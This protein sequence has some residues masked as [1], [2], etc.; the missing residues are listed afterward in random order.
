VTQESTPRASSVP[1]DTAAVPVSAGVLIPGTA[2]QQA[3]VPGFWEEGLDFESP[4]L[5]PGKLDLL[6]RSR[7]NI[8]EYNLIW[9]SPIAKAGVGVL[10]PDSGGSTKYAG[11]YVRPLLPLDDAGELI[12]GGLEVDAAGARSYEAQA[13]YR[14][15]VGFGLG[16]GIVERS[17]AQPDVS[18]AKATYRD[19]LE[20]LSYI[21]AAQVQ[22]TG[23]NTDPGGYVALYDEELLGV[24]G[25]DGE[26]WRTTLNYIAPSTEATLRPAIEGLYVD[27]GVGAIDGPQFLFI[28]G[29][30]K[31]GGGFLS[32]PASLG[33]AM[34]PQG[35]EFGNP[36]GFL[37]P[38]W[39]RRLETWELGSL[40]NAR[41]VRTELPNGSTIANYEAV[42][43]PFQLDERR[44]LLDSLLLGGFHND[45]PGLHTPG[46]LLGFSGPAGFLSL[47]VTVRHEFD[48]GD[49]MVVIGLIDKFF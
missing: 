35:L 44:N 47:S 32:H 31:F 2:T 46:V 39:N 15:P 4:L 30:L 40:L 48:T 21:L 27:N 5:S 45:A 16:G 29:T 3:D 23:S 36:L 38:T 28:N 41:V 8:D 11:G 26:Q 49:A 12:I 6:Y 43:F 14:F 1:H 10:D 7:P 34:G 9:W 24:F 20:K 17:G 42:T 22:E 13:E 25:H 33:R 19:R 18:F 37:R